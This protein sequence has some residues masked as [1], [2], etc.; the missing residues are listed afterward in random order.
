MSVFLNKY[1][2]SSHLE[3]LA[4]GTVHVSGKIAEFA[5]H[6]LDGM[7]TGLGRLMPDLRPASLSDLMRQIKNEGSAL[8]STRNDDILI[9]ITKDENGLFIFKA[10]SSRIKP[11]VFYE[12]KNKR[13][14]WE[15]KVS[16]FLQ[17]KVSQSVMVVYGVS[18]R[19]WK[20]D[21]FPKLKELFETN[22]QLR[23]LT[24]KA[25][26]RLP[27]Q[28]P[29]VYRG[30]YEDL[31]AEMDLKHFY[32]H[33]K[34]PQEEAE[35]RPWDIFN[36]LFLNY[37][38]FSG[39]ALAPWI[40]DNVCLT[41][42]KLRAEQITADGY[43]DPS[44]LQEMAKNPALRRH[45][46][47][48]AYGD[49]LLFSQLKQVKFHPHGYTQEFKSSEKNIKESYI[50]SSD[51]ETSSRSVCAPDGSCEEYVLEKS[52]GK[53][54][55]TQKQT[56]GTTVQVQ[57][58]TFKR[59][60]EEWT[61]VKEEKFEE[62]RVLQLS[63]R[64]ETAVQPPFQAL[65]IRSNVITAFTALLLARHS[66]KNAQILTLIPLIGHVIAENL[67][68]RR[69]P[70]N[71]ANPLPNLSVEPGNELVQNIN[72][73][74]YCQMSNPADNAALTIQTSEGGPLPGWL[75]LSMGEISLVKSFAAAGTAR[76]VYINGNYLY[77]SSGTALNTIDITNPDNPLL[78]NT[79]PISG[80]LRY[81]KGNYGFVFDS[82]GYTLLDMSNAT[83]PVIVGNYVTN[84][85]FT[86]ASGNLLFGR[87]VGNT[88]NF[89]IVDITN[90]T[91][92][93]PLGSTTFNISPIEGFQLVN[94][95][96]FIGQFIGYPTY[97]INVTNP[98]NPVLAGSIPIKEIAAFALKDNILFAAG[99][100]A[101]YILDITQE[102]NPASI[103]SIYIGSDPA[104]NLFINGNFLVASCYGGAVVVIDIED[105][106]NPAVVATYQTIGPDA[107]Q[108]LLRNNL[109]YVANDN[110]GLSIL[111]LANLVLSGT[112]GPSDRGLLLLDVTA[113]DMEGDT[114]VD[115]FAI[116]VGDITVPSVP[117]QQVYV[118][119][120][121]LFTFDAFEYPNA[122]FTY[123]TN[124]LPPFIS[125]DPPSRTFLFAPVSGDQ[126]TYT[127]TVTADDG[128][129]G[130][131]ST[132]FQLTIP[133][134]PPV[135]S[136]PLSD[137]TALTGQYFEYIFD[138]FTD[139]DNDVLIY[140]A[141]EEG[142][143]A[144]PGWLTL[145]SA[146]RKLYGTPFGQAVYAIQI[147][148]NDQHG[149]FA[150]GNFT[151]TVPSSPPVLLTGI[152]SQLATVGVEY[153]YT[154]PPDTFF[155][156]DNYPFNYTASGPSFLSFDPATRTFSG[157]PMIEDA[158]THT[159]VLTAKIPTNAAAV[160]TFTL[161]VLNSS[162]NYLPPVVNLQIP[163][164]TAYV[165][166]PFAYIIDPQTFKDPQN[167]TM[168][169][170]ASLEGGGPLP[171]YLSFNSLTFSATFAQP[172]SLRVTVRATNQ[173]GAY[174][175]DTF[176]L[177]V[178]Q[179][180]PP[181]VLN[182]LPDQTATVDQEFSMVVP[183]NTFVDPNGFPF[184]ISVSSAPH[185]LKWDPVKQTLSGK[186]GPFD[187]GAFS[188]SVTTIDVLAKN[189]VGSVKT[190]FRL[191]VDGTSFWSDFLKVVFALG[192]VPAAWESRALIWNHFFKKRYQKEAQTVLVNNYYEH[193]FKIDRKDMKEVK[194]LLN[195]NPLT[196]QKPFP[197]GLSYSGNKLKGTPTGE[198]RGR[199]IVRAINHDGYIIEEFPLI[200]KEDGQPDPEPEKSYW[201]KALSLRTKCLNR[202]KDKNMEMEAI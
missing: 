164:T 57:K 74:N 100:P 124:P 78:I 111:N 1:S 32:Q 4:S 21:K 22:G 75:S 28:K 113:S 147:T 2:F 59:D 195:G 142:T 180:L 60:G 24:Q 53:L 131:P 106:S 33:Q 125:F 133:D 23:N 128:N 116:H 161:T 119:N 145:D 50:F 186:P 152:P 156:V 80:Y 29:L 81:M 176:A 159:I 14:V 89:T 86:A 69:N 154:F 143:G 6:I 12:E 193:T 151:I 95:Y 191:T 39:F 42:L 126:G 88:A 192:S 167:A 56:A 84:N 15:A 115:S 168:T 68:S 3:Y 110:G 8:L 61:L 153:S 98:A 117:D 146:E 140:T 173:F 46:R 77:S 48:I 163:D 45:V 134:R 71:I 183:S 10:V 185:W 82:S 31:K 62:A 30:P 150:A 122:N 25:I 171:A 99:E 66:P 102:T 118:G 70:I 136:T 37:L 16:S 129:G 120:S 103:G 179:E 67:F 55:L 9:E 97:I 178:V 87:W 107:W 165:G 17:K 112:P 138:P 121:T 196:L 19:R 155:S 20:G 199:F 114:A 76:N 93:V 38:Y 96:V 200:I 132:S 105:I 201:E 63:D 181:T 13:D 130:T 157:M 72:L 101:I 198:D 92:P 187:T 73:N 144:L 40:Q 141:V 202:K 65:S 189:K 166:V 18:A 182:T 169:Y 174:T 139:K 26:L 197:D 108:T 194:V 49:D 104:Y 94:N 137:Q 158:G 7:T 162:N 64:V 190:T 135:L 79:L 184:N 175:L 91:A 172:Q 11:V 27:G 148:A 35:A 51:K 54:I 83:T 90:P 177:T 41:P 34:T 43:L 160:N 149:G 52:A 188:P 5:F 47:D 44:E 36:R 127:I 85:A 123:S 109:G 58:A 170:T